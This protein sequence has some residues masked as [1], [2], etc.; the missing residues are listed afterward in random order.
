[1]PDRSGSKLFDT[2]KVFLKEVFENVCFDK[3]C[4]TTKSVQ[5]GPE[6]KGLTIKYG[7]L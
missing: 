2:L 4:Q 3:K 6:G 1:M 5:N 7:F